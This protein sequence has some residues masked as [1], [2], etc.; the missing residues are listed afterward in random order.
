[1]GWGLLC[2]HSGTYL[3]LVFAELLPTSIALVLVT[4]ELPSEFPFLI[5]GL[6]VLK[7]QLYRVF[8]HMECLYL[9]ENL[10]RG[11]FAAWVIV[12]PDERVEDEAV[13]DDLVVLATSS[14]VGVMIGVNVGRV[15]GVGDS[16]LLNVS[17]SVSV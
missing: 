4:V 15:G 9:Y 11:F 1:M 7:F 6:S 13:E 8:E 10:P 5:D 3:L 14:G 17:G 12:N 16:E 2:G